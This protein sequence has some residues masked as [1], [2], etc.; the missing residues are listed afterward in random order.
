MGNLGMYASGIPVGMLIDARGPRWGVAL[1]TVLFGAGYYPIAKG[2][3]CSDM[4]KTRTDRYAAFDAG[5]GGYSIASLCLFSFFTGAG[6]CS[7]FTASIKT[8]ALN[9]PDHRGT[10]TAFPLAAFG[11]S[12]FCF[13]TIALALPED[14]SYFLRLLATGTVC[15]PAVSFFFLHSPS[16]HTYQ[17]LPQHESQRSHSTRSPDD[18]RDDTHLGTARLTSSQ[19]RKQCSKT[20]ITATHA[21]SCNEDPDSTIND[22]EHSSLLPSESDNFEDTKHTSEH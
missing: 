18:E 16:E 8:A 7:A 13:A 10:A 5:P 15:L 11:L 22:L 21:S 3:H 9:F 14:G 17:Q 2:G 12:A 20:R 19:H 4:I 6:S 1:G